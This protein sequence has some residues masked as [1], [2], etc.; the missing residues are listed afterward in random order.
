MIKF[1]HTEVLGWEHAIRGCRNPMNSWEKSDSDCTH[2]MKNH[3]KR[4]CESCDI[5]IGPNDL[6]LM[7]RLRNAG[8]DHR[9]YLRMITVYIDIIAPLYFYKEFDTYKVGTVANSCSTM[10]KGISKE[11]TLDDFSIEHMYDSEENK[12][13]D[14]ESDISEED[15]VFVPIKSFDGYVISNTGIIKKLAF[16]TTYPDGTIHHFK[17]RIVSQS[18][19]SSNYKKVVLRNKD[20]FK[21][22]YVHR[23]MAEA[24]VPNPENKPVVNH[25]DGNKWNN[26]ISNLEWVTHQE[27]DIHAV[28]LGLK[29]VSGY[30]RYRVG[31]T[32]RR[33]SSEEVDKIKEMYN[34][35]IPMK[36]IAKKMCCYDST[37]NNIIHGKTYKECEMTPLDSF[38]VI[39]DTLNELREMYIEEND[40]NIKKQIW[41]NIIQLLPSSYNQKRTV[42]MNY[43]VLANIYKSRKNHKLD[44]WKEFCEWIETLPYSEL[45]I[46]EKKEGE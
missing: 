44:E 42:M 35:G 25:K 4:D 17:E 27:N 30:N 31:K 13:F 24:F 9:K 32:A 34:S 38:K 36:E 2:C 40:K 7:K 10:H 28:S 19:N 26:N 16:D 11:F 21:N 15:E 6:D 1:E 18:V 29:K 8:T 14:V 45:I 22:C 20:T 43:E 5:Y 33:F 46:G 39:I 23:L 41:N 37:I 3:T 12:Y